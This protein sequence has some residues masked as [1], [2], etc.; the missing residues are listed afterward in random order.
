[1]DEGIFPWGA[2]A[3]E[4]SVALTIQIMDE[5]PPPPPRI[6]RFPAEGFEL[7]KALQDLQKKYAAHGKA[8]GRTFEAY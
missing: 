7:E 1:M 4:P 3:G 6:E 8:V 5:N 2:N